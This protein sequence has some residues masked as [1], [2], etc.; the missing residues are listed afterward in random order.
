[1]TNRAN[2]QACDEFC[3]LFGIEFGLRLFGLDILVGSDDVHYIIDCNY[4]SSYESFDFD[5][6]VK[7][8]DRLYEEEVSE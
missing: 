1:M 7:C 6:L 4:F 3:K 5:E 2:N 8:F